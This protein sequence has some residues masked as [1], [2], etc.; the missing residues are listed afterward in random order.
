[1]N[2][3]RD[4]SSVSTARCRSDW[5]DMGADVYEAPF[6]YI[7]SHVRPVRATARSGDRTGVPWWIHQRPRPDMR[8]GI[9]TLSRFIATPTVSK[10]RLFVWLTAPTLPDHQLI[11]FARDDDYFFGVLHSRFHEVW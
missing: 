9:E 10:H 5:P 4:A 3:P 1:M 8:S 7:R 11:I 2:P 6:E